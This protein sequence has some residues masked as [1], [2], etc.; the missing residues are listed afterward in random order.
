[1][2][3]SRQS[4]SDIGGM[5]DGSY[6]QGGRDSEPRPV[7]TGGGGPLPFIQAK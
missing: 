6:T 4:L 7:H 3:D 5:R 1:M 2:S